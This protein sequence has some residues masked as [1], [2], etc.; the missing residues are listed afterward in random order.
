MQMRV[1]DLRTGALRHVLSARA[2]CGKR[3]PDS[4]DP[5]RGAVLALGE[6]VVAAAYGP[7]A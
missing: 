7:Q 3:R 6:D 2:A 1:F 4:G 5:G